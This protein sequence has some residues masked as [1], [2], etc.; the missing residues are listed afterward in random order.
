M[1][2]RIMYGLLYDFA[3]SVGEVWRLDSLKHYKPNHGLTTG[4]F[5]TSLK[6]DIACHTIK[7]FMIKDAM[8]TN[9]NRLWNSQRLINSAINN[10]I[11]VKVDTANDRNQHTAQQQVKGFH[12]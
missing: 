2:V 4:R 6:E 11:V 12:W 9:R 8:V 5:T 3:Y 1:P 7:L 10:H